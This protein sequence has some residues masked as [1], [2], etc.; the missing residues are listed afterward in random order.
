MDFLPGTRDFV[1]GYD[2]LESSIIRPPK[3]EYEIKHLGP[4]GLAVKGVI[5]Q[6]EACMHGFGPLQQL[7]HVCQLIRVCADRTLRW[8]TPAATRSTSRSGPR[9]R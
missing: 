5:A 4:R 1:P 6:R 7:T 9:T 3:H 8:S 2:Y